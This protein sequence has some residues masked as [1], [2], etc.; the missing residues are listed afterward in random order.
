MIYASVIVTGMALVLAVAPPAA[1]ASMPEHQ[2]LPGEWRFSDGPEF[3]GAKGEMRVGPESVELDFDFRGG[4]NYVMAECHFDDPIALEEIGLQVRKPPSAQ[5]TVRITDGAGQQFQKT[6]FYPYEGWRQLAFTLDGWTVHWGGPGDGIFRQPVRAVGIIIDSVGL[7]ETQGTVEIAGLTGLPGEEDDVDVPPATHQGAYRV[8]DFRSDRDRWSPI[9]G[10]LDAG[11]WRPYFDREGWAA[12]QT[13]IS[14]FGQPE[15]IHLTLRGGAPGT[16]VDLRLGSHFQMF[17]QE[18]GY[19]DGGEQTFTIAAPPDGWEHYGGQDDGIVRPPLRINRILFES[20]DPE[21]GEHPIELVE[22][23]CTTTTPKQDAVVLFGKLG[24]GER[25]GQLE[26]RCTA[27]NLLEEPLEGRLTV[28]LTDWVQETIG[29]QILPWTVPAGGDPVLETA[30]FDLPE[31]RNYAEASFRF[32]AGAVAPKPVVSAYTRPIVTAADGIQSDVWGR[33]GTPAHQAPAPDAL[34]PESPWG[35]GVYLYRYPDNPEGWAEMDRAA[36]KARDAGVKWSRE[37]FSWYQIEREEGTYYFD[38]MDKVVETAKRHGITIYGLLTYWSEFTEPY[39]EQGNAEFV[40]WARAVVRR[41]KDDIKHWEIYNEPN[42]F[43][44][45]GPK[46]LYPPLLEACYEM[47]KE[48]DPEA[49]VLGISTAGIDFGFI[50]KCLEAGAPMD[51]LTV[52]PYRHHIFEQG[53]ISELQK[54]SEMVGDLPVWITEMG[55]STQVSGTPMRD[56]AIMLARSYLS[57][58]ASGVAPNISWYNF[59]NDGDDPFYNEHNFGVL[60]RDMTPKPAYRAYATMTRALGHDPAAEFDDAFVDGVLALEM[61]GATVIW[62]P[63][64]DYAL[65]VGFEGEPPAVANLMGE[66]AAYQVT[67]QRMTLEL[68]AGYPL[69]VQSTGLSPVGEPTLLEGAEA[70]DIIRF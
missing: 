16:R 12:L 1:A 10:D 28:T 67:D 37:E 19:L 11:Q 53:F 13:S 18:L 56:Q 17:E 15:Q 52:H 7:V 9:H 46:E 8:S 6:V 20:D 66:A 32:E 61:G 14:L 51:V 34:V 57:A 21:A 62:A 26:A 69:F 38:Y 39:T 44:W 25:E 68:Q 43:F 58:L 48:E 3:P 4:G 50:E 49:Q 31:D 30:H 33:D 47:I 63:T 45:S 54:A 36:A 2:P 35:M 5:L 60:F 42:I 22:L 29:E 27:W 55:W 70:T 40:E 41:Y 65:D 59:R 23:R 24:D 64:G